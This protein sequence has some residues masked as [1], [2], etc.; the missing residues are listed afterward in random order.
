LCVA[1]R[2]LGYKLAVISCAFSIVTDRVR[3]DLGLDFAF[4][5]RLE[6][7]DR[8]MTGALLGS[9]ID[10]N[11]KADLVASIALQEGIT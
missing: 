2:K 9:V 11:R 1:L 4:S 6:V 5:N 3:E 8:L 10:S 7:K